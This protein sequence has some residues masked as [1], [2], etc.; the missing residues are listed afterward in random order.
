MAEQERN[1][2]VVKPG[3][4]KLRDYMRKPYYLFRCT[5]CG[6]EWLTKN[7][8][9]QEAPGHFFPGQVI[10]IHQTIC[11]CCKTKTTSNML[12]SYEEFMKNWSDK[13]QT[14]SRSATE[15]TQE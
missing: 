14:D 15:T 11:P 3:N 12:I 10:T 4:A 7:Y 5:L 1:Y 13:M 6:M 9:E 8:T 2:I